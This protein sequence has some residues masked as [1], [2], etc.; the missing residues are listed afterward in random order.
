MAVELFKIQLVGCKKEQA[1][2]TNK[3]LQNLQFQQ[4]MYIKL[5]RDHVPIEHISLK[6]STGVLV[7]H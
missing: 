7:N 3:F 4:S 1:L 6:C 5:F 2:E